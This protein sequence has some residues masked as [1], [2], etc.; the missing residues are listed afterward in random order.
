MSPGIILD[1]IILN[2]TN[3]TVLSSRIAW[4]LIDTDVNIGLLHDEFSLKKQNKLKIMKSLKKPMEKQN[5]K[6]GITQ[7]HI[8][9]NSCLHLWT[10]QNS[11][12]VFAT[13]YIVFDR[14]F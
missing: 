1:S 7:A 13:N 11:K 12:K 5:G 10:S 3:E 6:L 2:Q 4:G 9:L 8:N 14:K